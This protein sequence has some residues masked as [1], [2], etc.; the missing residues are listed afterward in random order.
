MLDVQFYQ[1]R[2]NSCTYSGNEDKQVFVIMRLRGQK[3]YTLD[4]KL[5]NVNIT[6]YL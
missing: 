1:T 4:V 2:E 6:Y 3:N 5:L